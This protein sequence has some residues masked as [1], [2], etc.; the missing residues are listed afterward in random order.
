MC[1]V[2]KRKYQLELAVFHGNITTLR[3][4]Q[5][6]PQGKLG[7]GGGGGGGEKEGKGLLWSFGII[8]V[9]TELQ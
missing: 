3:S 1:E 5:F 8:A 6:T 2:G 7:G 9:Q 4:E